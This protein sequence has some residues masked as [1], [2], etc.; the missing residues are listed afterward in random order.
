MVEAEFVI[1]NLRGQVLNLQSMLNYLESREKVE[2][3]DFT[4]LHSKLREVV[5]QLKE[6]ERFS[7][8]RKS[9]PCLRAIGLN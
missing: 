7:S 5:R 8:Q 6:M 9:L 4:F 3:E 1:C 2:S